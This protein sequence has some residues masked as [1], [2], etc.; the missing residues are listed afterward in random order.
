MLPNYNK[1]LTEGKASSGPQPPPAGAAA[2]TQLD[3]A[4]V[5]SRSLSSRG[6]LEFINSKSPKPVRLYKFRV[7]GLGLALGFRLGRSGRLDY[8]I[9]TLGFGLEGNGSII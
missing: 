8:D 4:A 7:W 2:R 1:A 9:S 3:T 6:L 5:F